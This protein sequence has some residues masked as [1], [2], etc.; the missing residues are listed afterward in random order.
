MNLRG[1]ANSVTR[2]LNPNVDATRRRST[3]YTTLPGG[4]R[5]PAYEDI[6]VR[7]Q[8]QALAYGD[9]QK[10][11]G[12]NLQGYRRKIYTDGVLSGL[13]RVGQK[14]GDLIVFDPTNPLSPPEG[15]IWLCAHV[16]EQ[17]SPWCT[18]AITLQNK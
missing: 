7:L 3:G 16:L 1:V 12:L 2:V 9:I 4:E 5:V 15:T 17:W 6:P 11:D 10:I 13:I 18:V 8:V 14:G